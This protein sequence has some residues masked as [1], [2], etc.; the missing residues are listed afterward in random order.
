MNENEKK[1]IDFS[2]IKNEMPMPNLVEIQ[3]NSYEK[4]LKEDIQ[5]LFRSISPIKEITGLSLYFDKVTFDMPKFS[6]AECRERELTYSAGMKVEASLHNER[7]GEIKQM[8][9]FV[10]NLPMMTPEGTFVINGAERTVIGQLVRAPGVYFLRSQKNKD[11]YAKI[12]PDRGTWIE[13]EFGSKNQLNIKLDKTKKVPITTFLR[14][15]GFDIDM[16][17]RCVTLASS[18]RVKDKNEK[19]LIGFTCAEDIIDPNTG[20][21]L[22]KKGEKITNEL[23]VKILKLNLE[24]IKISEDCRPFI[25]EDIM[26][27]TAKRDPS[28]TT[29]Q[30]LLD[31]YRKLRPGEPP[32]SEESAV[33]MFQEKFFYDKFFNESKYNLSEV[34]RYK[35]NKKLKLNSKVL[36][37][38]R[39]DFLETVRYLIA[40]KIKEKIDENEGKDMNEFLT[41]SEKS[42]YEQ[43]LSIYN[44]VP[45]EDE[46]D[47]LG[48]RRVRSVGELLINK[49]RIGLAR[50]E[51][52]IREKMIL[53]DADTA[54][55][56][57]LINMRPLMSSIQEFFGTNPLSQF[58]D[59]T[60]PISSL[61]HRRRISAMG[62][63]GLV[64]ERA[65]FEVRDVHYSHYGR[66]CPIE[67][68]EGPNIGLISSMATYSKV[69]DYGFLVTPY[70]KVKNG[71]V[72][73]EVVYLTADQEEGVYIASS[74]SSRGKKGELLGDN[75]PVRYGDKIEK[76]P[77][78]K[79]QFIEVSPKQ[80]IS[81]TTS[82]IPF[83]EHD[84]ANRALMG[85]N[86]Q[87][88]AVPLLNPEVP[89]VGTGVEEKA[90]VDSG[91]VLLAKSDGKVV[92]VSANKI[93]IRNDNGQD[94][95]YYLQKFLRSNQNTVVDQKPLVREGERV[96]KDQ[97]IADG[98]ATKDGRLAL[99][100]N[101]LTAIMP[102]EG[103]NYEDAI[104]V[105]DRLVKEDILSSIFIDS[106]ECE[107]RDTRLGPEEITRDIPNV[108]EDLLQNLDE[109]GIV[110][111]GTE[112]KAGEIIVG[113][114]IPRGESEPTPEEKLLRAIFGEKARDVRNTSLTLEPGSKGKV[115]SVKQFSQEDG[116]P[117]SPGK[118]K[119]VKVEIAQ[120]RHIQEGDKLAGRHG[121]KGVISKVVPE[122]DMPFMEDGTI[123]DIIVNPLGVPSRMN[124][125]QILEA[126]LGWAAKKLGVTM[127]SPVFNGATEE[128]I[129]EYMRKANLPEDGKVTL[130]DGKTGEPF[131]EKVSVG[132]MYFMKLNHMVEDKMHARS[133]G[134]Y[135]LVTQQPLGGKSQ[136]GG[137][138][139]GEMEVWA[140]ESYGG[141]VIL[142]EL[143][144][145]K[146]DDVTGRVKTY[147]SIMK[148]ENINISGLPESF[149]V[150]VKEL[151]S[152]ALDV[153]LLTKTGKR[154]VPEE[155]ESVG[156]ISRELGLVN[157][158][159]KK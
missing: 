59:Q 47:H 111:V 15:I 4:F 141:S 31:I 36:S 2:K 116:E 119:L 117:F 159:R 86:M 143:L 73:N 77:P 154:V 60:N 153:A 102:W 87:R 21:L 63:G 27:S 89:L 22:I 19:S 114:V 110:K 103:Y 134:S 130:Y 65:G 126:H 30:A 49:M 106:Y 74:Y 118:R 99:G 26:L 39:E 50:V 97:I 149:N 145:I 20:E 101:L 91:A 5:E 7:T 57:T 94:D 156:S 37:L 10:G 132:Y 42:F 29:E 11:L 157:I 48:N 83:L 69:N 147:E 112:V 108:N 80:I 105:S 9:V 152:L 53:Q 123:I 81:I 28:D 100:C 139:F 46:I 151:Q 72:T 93:V 133:T 62:P 129:K 158:P 79:V 122:E 51:K 90:A 61:T 56:L 35:L 146:S 76:V 55:P 34:G 8:E 58:M 16:E 144:T 45:R 127:V 54:T 155:D 125:G 70:F 121:N 18:L 128:E 66:T 98:P 150:L 124:L 44:D 3:I 12:I 92:Y 17:K 136:F 140:L 138:R 142:Q 1:V 82:L 88:Q 84:D 131:D 85:S 95:I 104:V 137:Q 78:S 43:F 75:I 71:V 13:I 148:G 52:I 14:A 107:A 40:L 41:K 96:K 115:I 6:P 33:K 120:L 68:P 23:A 109:R 32:I 135:A 38:T 25:V 113:K 67:S 24:E 64:R